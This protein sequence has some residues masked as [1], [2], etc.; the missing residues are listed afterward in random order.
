MSSFKVK[1]QPR[2]TLQLQNVTTSALLQKMRLNV[3]FLHANFQR[4]PLKPRN[5]ING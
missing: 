2:I 3:S 4:N 5:V 1:I